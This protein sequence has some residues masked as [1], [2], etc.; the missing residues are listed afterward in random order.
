MAVGHAK[1][2]DC[3]ADER[4][5]E[6]SADGSEAAFTALVERYE[7]ALLRHCS[8]VVGA[9]AAQDVVQDTFLTAWTKL[10]E[11]V[12]VR[13]VRPWLFTI[14]H[15]RA[16]NLLRDKRRR[17]V[18]LSESYAGG[19]SPAEEADQFAHTRAVL[20]AVAQLPEEQR[21]ALLRSALHG[22]S[23]QQ[24]AKAM[25]VDEPTVRQLVYRARSAVRSAAAAC[26]VPPAILLRLVRR[27]ARATSQL[28]GQLAFRTDETQVTVRLLKAGAAA[29]VGVTLVGSAALQA[30]HPGHATGPGRSATDA[31]LAAP[32]QSAAFKLQ[33]VSPLRNTAGSASRPARV[34]VRTNP[35]A[36]VPP[37]GG[38]VTP[39]YAVA[40]GAPPST[41]PAAPRL[42]T[43]TTADVQSLGQS[44]GNTVSGLQQTVQAALPPSVPSVVETVQN[45]VQPT[46]TGATQT[47]T[48]AVHGL[49]GTPQPTTSAIEGLQGVV[50]PL[51]GL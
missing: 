25:G 39:T 4:L 44:A 26:L 15:R 45:S 18:E 24:I 23:G 36:I 37:A 21:E 3:D 9:A 50:N 28:G 43:S 47:A 31:Q 49:L 7:P 48:G 16:L 51:P 10:R 41:G 34:K 13:A 42:V 38:S 5:V 14:A 22:G 1:V 29:I 8:G 2:T 40:T 35:T 32:P 27:L 12:K 30:I 11:G 33:A 20:K 6:L 17:W 46:L 19:R